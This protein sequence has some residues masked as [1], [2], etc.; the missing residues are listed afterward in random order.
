MAVVFQPSL[1]LRNLRVRAPEIRASAD[2]LPIGQGSSLGAAPGSAD[3][4]MRTG[5][6]GDVDGDSLAI[7]TL[8]EELAEL[9]ELDQRRHA[10]A[11]GSP[12][13]LDATRE[14]DALSDRLMARA[15]ELHL[16]IPGRGLN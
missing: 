12:G 3:W 11:P 13:F 5:R 9:R 10:H 15:R 14:V 16:R 1:C 4:G 6:N 7:E 8:L 2:G